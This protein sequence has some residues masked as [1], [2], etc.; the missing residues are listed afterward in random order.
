MTG[1]HRLLPLVCLLVLVGPAG[2]QSGPP[3]GT[4]RGVFSSDPPTLD[5]A[6]A[7]DTTSSAVVP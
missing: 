1:H 7:T 5:P 6:Q 3:T 4:L 2:A